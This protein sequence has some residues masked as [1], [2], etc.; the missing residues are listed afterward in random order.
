MKYADTNPSAN[1]DRAPT[2]LGIA[3]LVCFNSLVWSALTALAII[4]L[5][6]LGVLTP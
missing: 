5:F 3:L 4:A 2:M 1:V 6:R